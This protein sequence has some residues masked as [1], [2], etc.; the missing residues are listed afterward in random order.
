ML[1]LLSEIKSGNVKAKCAET[2]KA[3]LQLIHERKD[4]K[5]AIDAI[6]LSAEEKIAALASLSKRSGDI[7]HYW[8]AEGYY[9]F[10]FVS[11]WI[12]VYFYGDTRRLIEG[13][14]LDSGFLNFAW[15]DPERFVILCDDIDGRSRREYLK[16][17][18]NR[19]DFDRFIGRKAKA[20]PRRRGPKVRLNV[21]EVEQRAILLLKHNPAIPREQYREKVIEW[22]GFEIG[23]TMFNKYYG[24]HWTA[25]NKRR[26]GLG[27]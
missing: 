13:G 24:K 8:F 22:L 4:L 2:V 11:D 10:K 9:T 18:F 17:E 23:E 20:A 3:N 19:L 15:A 12:E 6:H 26:K 14:E 1:N 7:R 16:V 27:I 25:N 21:P 5:G